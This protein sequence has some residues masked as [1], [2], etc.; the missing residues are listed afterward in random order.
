MS[1]LWPSLIVLLC[2]I[3]AGYV[4]PADHGSEK[5]VKYLLLHSILTELWLCIHWNGALP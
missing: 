5:L 2:L 4:H 3:Q 1:G